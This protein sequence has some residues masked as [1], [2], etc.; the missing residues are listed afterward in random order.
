MPRI[1]PEAFKVI[2]IITL[3]LLIISG[4]L[5]YIFRNS[6]EGILVIWGVTIILILLLTL[7]FRH[8]Q[9][10]HPQNSREVYS[11]A[12]GEVVVIE[13]VNEKEYIS[14]QCIQLSVFMSI[15]NV[16][17]NWSPVIGQVIYEKYHPGKFFPAWMPKSSK[18]NEHNTFAL[19]TPTNHVIMVRQIAGAVARRIAV[20]KHVGDMVKAGDQLGFIRFGS[21]VD[22][23]L[24]LGS[25]IKVKLGDKVKGSQTLM[26]ILPS[27]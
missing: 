23:F 10:P 27:E 25:E 14:G 15:T 6:L 18:M 16:H 1:H 11:S 8:P 9:R 3:I 2:P 26:A 19:K 7:F 22:M 13:E 20:Y 4:I 24:P 5:T 21:R 17:I 12:D